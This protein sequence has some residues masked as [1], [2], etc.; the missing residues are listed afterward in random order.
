MDIQPDPELTSATTREMGN[1]IFS[2]PLPTAAA[3]VLDQVRVPQYGHLKGLAL[4]DAIKDLPD[5]QQMQEMTPWFGPLSIVLRYLSTHERYTFH[6]E[7]K[8]NA[9]ARLKE[10]GFP[11]R[12]DMTRW[13]MLDYLRQAMSKIL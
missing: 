11:A 8:K 9:L 3:S 7:E 12:P 5:W 4:Y 6:S 10:M 1:I 2:S 13:R